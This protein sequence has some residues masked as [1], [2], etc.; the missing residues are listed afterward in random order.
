VTGCGIRGQIHSLEAQVARL[1]Y[2]VSDLE[3]EKTNLEMRIEGF[4]FRVHTMEGEMDSHIKRWEKKEASLTKEI[5]SLKSG[6]SLE[7]IASAAGQKSEGGDSVSVVA[8]PDFVQMTVAESEMAAWRLAREREL[9]DMIHLLGTTLIELSHAEIEGAC[10]EIRGE[11]SQFETTPTVRALLK[12]GETNLEFDGVV[13][14]GK[15]EELLVRW[16]S[17][18]LK[19]AQKDG[20]LLED[21]IVKIHNLGADLDDGT[22]LVDFLN[23]VLPDNYKWA[24]ERVAAAKLASASKRGQLLTNTMV[25]LTSDTAWEQL[26][27]FFEACGLQWEETGGASDKPPPGTEIINA[28]L[29]SALLAKTEFT[30]E[31][32]D[33]FNVSD[34]A[35]GCYINAGD[36]RFQPAAMNRGLLLDNRIRLLSVVYLLSS[37]LTGS[38][39]GAGLQLAS[40][41]N[42]VQD[43]AERIEQAAEHFTNALD[44]ARAHAAP[45]D[46]FSTTTGA[47][48]CEAVRML[49]TLAVEARRGVA[50]AQ[51]LSLSLSCACSHAFSLLLTL[52]LVFAQSLSLSRAPA[53]SGSRSFFLYLLPSLSTSFP[54]SLSLSLFPS[55]SLSLSHT[56]TLSHSLSLTHTLSLAH[57]HAHTH[58]HTQDQLHDMLSSTNAAQ[59]AVVK[60]S[61]TKSNL[62]LTHAQLR[63]KGEFERGND[64][65]FRVC[66]HMYLP[67]YV[68]MY[69]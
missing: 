13:A 52:S 39:W 16:I 30:T 60:M 64:A 37:G 58:T 2:T 12:S 68:Y 17:S 11:T 55:L 29:A 35:E 62:A 4:Q 31:E 26:V 69:M 6:M 7:H 43:A 24:E 46:A 49:G 18:H 3:T 51:V 25:D 38:L 42:S 54:L 9:M 8:L 47:L 27:L 23:V 57:T 20:L 65:G 19:Q 61:S 40:H 41:F 66:V 28:P 50:T 44:A 14:Q 21:A 36:K 32:F 10:G 15:S 34:L 53:L 1:T 67:I 59:I 45:V 5:E 48:L 63:C 22:V 56:H 33:V